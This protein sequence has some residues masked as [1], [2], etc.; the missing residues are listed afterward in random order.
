MRVS[1]E[2]SKVIKAYVMTAQVCGGVCICATFSV[3]LESSCT[4]SRNNCVLP[5]SP[6]SVECVHLCMCFKCKCVHAGLK[7]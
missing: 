3:F 5:F 7:C 1:D 2:V 4:L 6:L